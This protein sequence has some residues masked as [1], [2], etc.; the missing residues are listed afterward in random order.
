[1]DRP[2]AIVLFERLYLAAWAIGL[3]GTALS[4]QATIA[5]LEANPQV[6]AVGP[7]FLYG[8][9]ALRLA[10]PLILWYFIARRGSVVAKW[11]AVALFALGAVAIAGTLLRGA[12]PDTP[13]ALLGYLGFALQLGAIAMLFRPDAAPWFGAHEGDVSA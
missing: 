11:I 7:G 1:M 5:L 6:A 3:L 10:V 8:T 4:W 12:F 9:T 13:G 2:R